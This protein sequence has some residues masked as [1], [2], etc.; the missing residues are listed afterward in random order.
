MKSARYFL[1]LALALGAIAFSRNCAV[2][3]NAQASNSPDK[4]ADTPDTGISMIVE[5]LVRDAACP[6]QNHK[7]TA[8]HFNM[9][10]ALA[11]AKAGSP[12]VILT[13]TDEIYYPMK[14]TM[15]DDTGTREKLLPYV[16]KFVR[17]SGTVYR[18]NGTRA[19]VIKSISEMKDVKL[20]TNLGSD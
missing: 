10:C 11:C 4:I 6:V 13:R 8:T 16:G 7:S 3:L 9:Q 2:S 15:P 1:C 14:E 18:R 20:D 19:I 12:L 17:V 5:G